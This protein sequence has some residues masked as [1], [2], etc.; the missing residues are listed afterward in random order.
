MTAPVV[1]LG[2]TGSIGRQAL[3]VA[4]HLGLAVCGIAARRPSTHLVELARA[5]P[6][7]GVVVAGGSSEERADL[8]LA[9]PDRR[10][11]FGAEAIVAM[12]ATP[13]TTVVNGIVGF[14]GLR[15]SIAALVSGNRL[16][17]ANK[18]S[19]VTAGAL[20]R[21]AAEAGGGDL[22]PV[23][24]EHSALLQCMQGERRED[25]ARIILTASGGPFRGF[26]REE[27]AEVTVDQALR[28]P[29]WEMGRRI[30]VDSAT[31]MNKGF[32]VIEAHV[33]FEQPYE[34]IEVLIHPQSV[35]HSMVE[36]VDGSFKAH[37]GLTD[38]RI[39][40]QYAL[41]YP[42]RR[43]GLPAPFALGGRSLQFESVDPSSYPALALAFE[44]GRRGG[45]APV[46]L[47]AADEVAVSAFL[48]GRIGFLS[49]TEV[50]ERSLALSD[51]V[52]ITDVNDVEAVD[53][54]AR[55]L[56]ASLISGVC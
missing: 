28:H 16:A 4:R 21:A 45:S 20:V 39:P 56:A 43:P 27:L 53:R 38:M 10:V 30:T 51:E 31:L 46:V 25:V 24:S 22:I 40:I 5:W 34:R 17:L 32:E 13:A 29:T 14:A 26:A 52:A 48:Q 11:H 3:E 15:A 6:E 35:V 41:T 8:R 12:A 54:E 50:V 7:A 18:E 44:A 42:H 23:D 2:A 49:I 37:L 33:L 36:F 1:V 19:L 9:L 47:N 55:G